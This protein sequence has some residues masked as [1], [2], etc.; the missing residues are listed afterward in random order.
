MKNEYIFE[1]SLLEMAITEL[2]GN[3]LAKQYYRKT[4]EKLGV[5]VDDK[6]LD[7][8]SGSG[9]ISKEILKHLV[10][11]QLIYAD[12]SEKWL[13]HAK[14]KLKRYKNA[15]SEKIS[16][17]QGKISG[18]EYD[19]ILMHFSLHDFPNE[20]RLPIINQLIENLKPTGRLYIREPLSS[21]HGFQLHE[22]INL[23]EY[24]KKLIYEYNIVKSRFVG[25]YVEIDASLK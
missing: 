15:K 4:V 24:T 19:K 23:L 10:Q 20:Y 13:M 12:V 6:A 16:G 17:F 18:G 3:M 9:I 8:C 11:G 5:A 14:E 25:E 1:P 2:I 7:Y 21:T 22:L